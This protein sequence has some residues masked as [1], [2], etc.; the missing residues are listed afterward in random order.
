MTIVELIT[1][2][3]AG[4]RRRLLAV[5]TLAG[6][7]NAF[8]LFLINSAAETPESSSISLFVLFLM[9]IGLY[10]VGA[11]HTYHRTT[12]LIEASLHRIR[13]RVMAKV[14]RTEL[15]AMERVG[16]TEIIDRITENL[17]VI[18]DS[19]GLLAHLLQSICIIVF[20]TFFLAWY[21]LP[22]F[23]L[24]VLLITAGATI[25]L[26]KQRHVDGYL[27]QA[28]QERL[29]FSEQITDLLRGFKEVKY[30]RARGR[31]LRED[32]VKSSEAMRRITTT[33]NDLFNDNN[34]FANC[35]QFV[36]MGALVFVLPRHLPMSAAT[37]GS[38]ISGLLFV[39]GP[40]AGIVSG[41]PA[42]IRSNHA[43]SEVEA[44]ERKLDVGARGAPSPARAED[45]WSGRFSKLEARDI[46]YQ[47]ASENGDGSFRIG[48]MSLTISA[49]EVVFIVG[50]NGS[51]KSTFLK[52]L[53]GLYRPSAGTLRVDG[54]LVQPD[55][56]A[57]YREMISTIYSDFHL[58][59]KLYGLLDID[60]AA[61][62][63]LLAQMQ[64]EGKTSF[65]DQRFTKR[66][67]S[68]GQRKRLAMI[69]VLLEDRPIYV[70]DEW[71]ADQDPE[72]R[73]YFYEE[74]I[75]SLKERG[76]A[77][78]AVSH[79]DRYFRCADR[80]VTM[81]YGKIRSIEPGASSAAPKGGPEPVV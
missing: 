33:T 3:A 40:M 28:A 32:V 8:I 46:E 54:L 56:A 26:T 74:L 30:S 81:E 1:K 4:E 69:V 10:V 21:S 20:A 5:A 34:I 11:R 78:I 18:S 13:T 49:G 41:F 2:E 72:F 64:L 73:K 50:G 66:N 31:Q 39:W 65:S 23:A 17:S 38:L 16:A 43:L 62:H 25:Y 51:G 37:L 14:E 48:P 75:P 6:A 19:A 9:S 70:F 12:Y 29:T 44:L 67:L 77:V 59:A 60:E 57:A 22:A 45:P 58:F 42:Y 61:V 80:V 15:E 47:Y 35:N 53:T 52:V 68:T 27:R 55:N 7:G 24:L 79:D 63:R 36:L 71:A 76:K